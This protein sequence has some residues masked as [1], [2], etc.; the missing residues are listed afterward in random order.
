MGRAQTLSRHLG[1]REARGFSSQG[2]KNI[3]WHTRLGKIEV[4][5]QTYRCTTDNSVVRPFARSASVTPRGYSQGLQRVMTDFGADDS[6]GEAVNK[7]REHYAIEVPQSAVREIT[8]K[9]AERM[10]DEKELQTQLPQLAVPLVI[11]HSDGCLVPVV[12]I[13]E[14]E[15]EKDKRKCRKLDW[16]E[17]RLSMGREEGRVSKH[18]QATMSGVEEAGA[19]LL[20][21]VIAAGAGLNT[22]IHCLGDGAVWIANQVKEKLGEKASYLIDFYHMS[23]YLAGAAEAIVGKKDKKQWLTPK[24]ELMKENR[25]S[26]VLEELREKVEK[27]EAEEGQ[28]PVRRCERYISNRIG[29]LDYKGAIEANLPIGSGEIESGNRV[30]IQKRLK[31]SGAWWKKENAD[32]MLALR[33]VRA[34]GEWEAYWKGLRQAAA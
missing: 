5:E 4:E 13:V 32:K 33:C 23:E 29:Q 15:G 20:D 11:A 25:V 2:K 18:Y 27:E 22:K 26:E 28:A 8:Q 1:E 6:F 14:K 3:C 10:R 16:K 21:C 17:A 7:M 34:N 9:H 24:Q 12:E 30:V 31:I 19:Q